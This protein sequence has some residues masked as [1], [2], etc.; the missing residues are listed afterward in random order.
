[1]IAAA[2][3]DAAVVEETETTGGEDGSLNIYV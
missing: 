3:I 1:M 2:T